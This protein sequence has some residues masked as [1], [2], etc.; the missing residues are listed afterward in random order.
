MLTGQVASRI[1]GPGIVISFLLA[2]VAAVLAALCYAE[3]GARAPRA[4]SAYTFVFMSLGEF[5]AFLIGWQLIM[6]HLI[7]A[8]AVARTW[9]AYLDSFL[10]HRI[11]DWATS[12]V[13]LTSNHTR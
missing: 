2:G 11:Q 6:E 1:A 12:A 4:G 13:P 8:A 9:S 5:P 10:G 7:G 3:L